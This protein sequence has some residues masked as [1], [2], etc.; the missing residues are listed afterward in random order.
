MPTFSLFIKLPMEIDKHQPLEGITLGAV[1]SLR[2]TYS[3]KEL[4]ALA[5]D[6]CKE[7]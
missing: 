4:D 3:E 6:S 1:E 5:L 7:M 2:S